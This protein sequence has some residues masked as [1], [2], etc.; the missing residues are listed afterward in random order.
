MKVM[1]MLTVQND[2]RAENSHF[3]HSD[4]EESEK[5][6]NENKDHNHDKNTNKTMITPFP[7]AYQRGPRLALAAS[8]RQGTKPSTSVQKS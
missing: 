5:D 7:L 3:S 4:S 6:D 8:K 2:E 1:S